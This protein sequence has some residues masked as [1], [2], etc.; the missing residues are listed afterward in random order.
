MYLLKRL[1]S[2]VKYECARYWF[3][4]VSTGAIDDT[5]P[6]VQTHDCGLIQFIDQWYH[7]LNDKASSTRDSNM[8]LFLVELCSIGQTTTVLKAL[9]RV[10]ILSTGLEE[11]V[12]FI[13]F[14]VVWFY[15][16]I[17]TEVQLVMQMATDH[18]AICSTDYD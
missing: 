13:A 8:L 18:M 7:C 5:I 3:L 17:K 6:S 14:Q 2:C 12:S 10:R 16:V 1:G 11:I 9:F 15:S 4:S